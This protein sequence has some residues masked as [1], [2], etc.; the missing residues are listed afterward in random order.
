MEV[1]MYS[2]V[3]L[4]K[5]SAFPDDQ[6]SV[7]SI[8]CSFIY[9]GRIYLFVSFPI[10]VMTYRTVHGTSG[11]RRPSLQTPEPCSIPFSAAIVAMDDNPG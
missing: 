1:R 3:R 4:M 6:W 10:R 2:T 5:R 8:F 11:D 9:L 7:Y